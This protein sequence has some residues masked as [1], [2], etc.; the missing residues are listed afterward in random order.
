M[1]R[2][3]LQARLWT[4]RR[5]WSRHRI[6]RVHYQF[7]VAVNH[8]FSKIDGLLSRDPNRHPGRR[9]LELLRRLPPPNSGRP[10]TK[11]NTDRC[12]RILHNR[13]ARSIALL[14]LNG[15]VNVSVHVGPNTDG[16]RVPDMYFERVRYEFG[17]DERVPGRWTIRLNMRNYN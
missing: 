5:Q 11:W 7:A 4:C 15:L 14:F 9:Q 12:A 6:L 16:N 13:D 1:K 17:L 3:R 8:N 2:A 10:T